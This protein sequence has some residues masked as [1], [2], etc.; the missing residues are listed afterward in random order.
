MNLFN[1]V[2]EEDQT[3]NVSTNT[4]RDASFIKVGKT[5]LQLCVQNLLWNHNEPWQAERK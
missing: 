4:H 5:F 1:S 3:Q 2:F